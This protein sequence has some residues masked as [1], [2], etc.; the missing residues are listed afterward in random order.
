MLDYSR[1]PWAVIDVEYI[2]QEEVVYFYICFA[3]LI[4]S[5]SSLVNIS[6]YQ[7]PSGVE[8]AIA[9]LGFRVWTIDPLLPGLQNRYAYDEPIHLLLLVVVPR[10]IVH[11][12]FGYGGLIQRPNF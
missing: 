3:I 9:L 6:L 7:A 5:S 2:E 10:L 8:S 12:L 1:T 11:Y 4:P